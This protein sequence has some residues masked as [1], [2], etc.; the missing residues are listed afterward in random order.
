MHNNTPPAQAQWLSESLRLAMFRFARLHIQPDEEAEDAVQDA[1]FA[2]VEHPEKIQQSNDIK[3]YLFGI[4]KNKVTDRLRQKY[5]TVQY[6]IVEQDDLEQLLFYDNG[7]WI[8]EMAPA[9]WNTPEDQLNSDLFFTVVD[10]CVNDLPE[11]IAR[12]FS[13]KEFLECEVS[14]ICATLNLSQT[15]YWQC[16]SR[17]RKR[18]QMCLNT[19]WFEKRTP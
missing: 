15:D 3:R 12:V 1:L 2:L 7:H 19:R 4:L 6:D 5:R 18:L 13:M 8:K 14:E 11:K 17:A 10:I 9:Y 16:M